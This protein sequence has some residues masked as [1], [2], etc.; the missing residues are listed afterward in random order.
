VSASR[1]VDPAEQRSA[2]LLRLPQRCTQESR[3]E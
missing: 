3:G 1:A 2:I